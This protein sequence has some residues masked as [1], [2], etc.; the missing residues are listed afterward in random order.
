MPRVT[1]VQPEDLVPHAL[2]AKRLDG[3][4]V[5]EV[6]ARWREAGG[7]LDPPSV[8]ATPDPA[9]DEMRVLAR[10]LLAELDE[11]AL[12]AALAAAEPDDLEAIEA[13]TPG[14]PA[15]TP[16]DDVTDRIHGGWLGRAAGCLLGK[17][18]EKIPRHGIRAIAESTGNWPIS[19]YFTAIGLDPDVAAAF[20]WNRASRTTSLVENIAGMPED[21][22]LNF[23][24]VALTLVE[25]HGE[26]LTTDDVAAAW[27]S[28][29]PGGRVFTAERI[30][31]RNLLDGHPPA[32]AGRVGNPFQDWI[33]A[34]I[35]TDVYGWVLPGEPARAARLA[36]QDGR[37]SHS[38]NGLYGAM[39]VAAASSVAPVAS[40]ID[41]CVEAG[42]SVV[43]TASRYAT[44]VRRGTELGHGRL[45]LGGGDRHDLRRVRSPPLGPRAQQR[46]PPGVRPDPQRGRLRHRCHDRRGRWLGHRL[47]GCDRRLDLRRPHRRDETATGVDRSPGQPSLDEHAGLR[48]HRLRRV[49]AANGGSEI[50]V[51]AAF[52]PL[53]PRPIDLPT[54][55]PLH[56]EIDPEVADRAKILA[57]PDDPADW[58]AWRDQLNRWRDDARRRFAVDYP[59]SSWAA[60]CFTKA[61]VWLWDERLFDRER[62]EF[63]ADRLLADAE[64]FGGFDAVVLWHAYPIIGLD[65]RNQFDYYRD[66]P[67]LAELV[68]ELQRR[69]VRVLLDYNPWDVG[70]RREPLSDAEV[71]ADVVRSLG[72][73]GVFL[74]TMREGGRDARFGAPP[75]RSA[76]RPRRRVAGATGAHRRSRDELGAVV[77]RLAGRPA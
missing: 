19:T 68:A 33:G 64:R 30:A 72:V 41:E 14:T 31:Y 6:T 44:A 58:P 76:T 9:T 25:Q 73:D 69:G 63:T 47:D 8:G 11:L 29:L 24:I 74:D 35:R 60:R 37:L 1:W 67:G 36:W 49:G 70:T 17:P 15:S 32:V 13:L 62:G 3:C 52:D 53:V 21:D 55:L 27:L 43:P 61:L 75:A 77:R 59:T 4:D 5:E 57:A 2:S 40:S 45:G 18:V 65:D 34:Q 26:A 54:T 38:R 42:L 46:C 22:D 23:A 12:P 28:L 10:Q 51:K 7:R 48:R 66:V 16:I 20:P 50:D 39:F 56:G 71:L